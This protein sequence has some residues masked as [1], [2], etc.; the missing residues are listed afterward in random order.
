MVSRYQRSSLCHPYPATKLLPSWW[1]GWNRV[2]TFTSFWL[3]HTE[4]LSFDFCK[5]IFTHH[6]GIV[7][8]SHR[9]I[10]WRWANE[11]SL[12]RL[13]DVRILGWQWP[14]SFP[15]VSSCLEQPPGHHTITFKVTAGP[16]T[17]QFLL[18]ENSSYETLSSP[19]L[20]SEWSAVGLPPT[21]RSKAPSQEE[22]ILQELLRFSW[23]H[24]GKYS[25]DSYSTPAT[26]TDEVI[27][28]TVFTT[29]PQLCCKEM[30]ICNCLILG[31]P[32]Q[33][34]YRIPPYPSQ[35][36]LSTGTISPALTEV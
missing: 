19:L 25:T 9:T 12:N 14:P 5:S 30:E 13:K 7:H 34:I 36:I 17:R 4:G 28:C 18:Q 2:N 33:S 35:S 27:S 8:S 24:L 11:D 15:V 23:S 16:N 21:P 32:P 20:T 22:S 1:S 10:V 3:T 31:S 6:C 26:L 29:G